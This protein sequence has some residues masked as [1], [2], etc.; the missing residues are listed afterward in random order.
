MDVCG[1]LAVA[2][3]PLVQAGGATEVGSSG[4]GCDGAMVLA[5]ESR[6]VV[7]EA[8]EGEFAYIVG[9]GSNVGSGE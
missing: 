4:V 7:C 2:V 1:L 5:G 3:V 8:G 6:S 9:L